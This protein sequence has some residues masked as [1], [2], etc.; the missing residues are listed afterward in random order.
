MQIKKIGINGFGRIG[1]L[2]MRVALEN[3]KL[4]IVAVNDLMDIEQLAYLL[5]YDSVHG[6]LNK[7]V[8]VNGSYLVVEGKSIRVTAIKEADKIDWASVGVDL[9]LDCTGIY[10]ELDSASK[11]LE[12]GAKKVVI[13]APSKTAPMFVMGVNHEQMTAEE[14]IISNAS[15][16]TNCLAPM[17]KIINDNFGLVEGLMTTIHAATASQSVIDQG[18]S[19]NYRLGRSALDNIIPT[20]TGAAVAVTKVVPELKGKLTGMAFR[21]PVANVSVVDLTFKTEKPTSIQEINKVFEQAS[22]NEYLGLVA[23]VEQQ[24]VS[25][26]F[27]SNTFICNYDAGASME[28]NPNFFKIVGWYDNEYAYAAKMV[29]LALH[30]LSL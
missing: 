11:H 14:T 4:E 21:V 17:A 12:A 25:Q 18:N 10:K 23:Y 26:D 20:S 19:K 6:T 1:R 2:A 15:C 7:E 27:V 13:S 3:P 22:Q 9:V 24:L 29:D 30:S 8:R 28:L 5:Q 16:T